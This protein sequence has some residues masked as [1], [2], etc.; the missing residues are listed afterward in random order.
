MF[1]WKMASHK[2]IG[3]FNFYFSNQIFIFIKGRYSHK[4]RFFTNQYSPKSNLALHGIP[5][6]KPPINLFLRYIFYFLIYYIFKNQ[7]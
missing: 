5:Q 4:S 3:F 2:R 6:E 7:C 1:T